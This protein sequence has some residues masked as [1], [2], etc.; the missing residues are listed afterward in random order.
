MNSLSLFIREQYADDPSVTSV[1]V[2]S[3]A[4]PFS[5]LI[6]GF[7]YLFLVITDDEDHADPIS[8]YIKEDTTIQERRIH[9]SGLEQWI[10]FGENHSI[11]QWILQGEICLDRHGYLEG[12]RHRLLEFPDEMRQQKLFIEFTLFLR[13]YLQAKQYSKENHSLDAYT[14]IL[15]ALLHW[16]R[17]A[18]IET[19]I[20]PEMTV[21]RQLR[22][23]NPGIYKLYEELTLSGE[24]LE[25][26]V[27]LVIL[28]CEFNVI[29]KMPDC[30]SVLTK[31]LESR[32]ESY[33]PTE[34]MQHPN[35]SQ[36]NVD[37][38]LVLKKL[39]MRGLIRETVVLVGESMNLEAL[40]VRYSS[41][42][43]NGKIL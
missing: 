41:V 34:L 40:E 30:C 38:A 25:Q 21:W 10:V 36:L 33:S 32:E 35:L 6:D 3:T 15:E 43:M 20:H 9:S 13:T 2:V 1:L 39:V 18:I 37:M 24:T 11:I 4:S 42:T 22:K 16:A 14:S 27:Q 5:P 19:G 7:D 8:H 28:A 23:I 29:S 12:V 17:I 31:V 26:R